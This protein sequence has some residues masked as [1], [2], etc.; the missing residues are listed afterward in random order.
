EWWCGEHEPRAS[1]FRSHRL[2]SFYLE[3][4][5]GVRI[6]VDL[7]LPARLQPGVRLPAI[8]C[9]TRY[10]R[11]TAFGW[12]LGPLF[13]AFAP[14]RATLG[15]ATARGYAFVITDV[16]GTGASFGSRQV[17]WSE[18]EVRDGVEVVDWIVRQPW[19]AGTVGVSG[20]SYVGTSAE[21]LMAQ[22]HPA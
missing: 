9:Q 6:A 13:A 15:R 7:Y 14:L 17:E 12:K 10:H 2:R 16:R 3:M 4:R 11:R 5:D 22:G 20:T 21:L 19:S 1:R 8:L 18:D